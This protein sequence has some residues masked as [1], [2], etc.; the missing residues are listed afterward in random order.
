MTPQFYVVTLGCGG[1]SSE[2]C[3][4]FEVSDPPAGACRSTFCKTD[5]VCQVDF[6]IIERIR[7]ANHDEHISISDKVRF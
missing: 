6:R 7:L 4:Y 2:N 1:T 5:N 3:T